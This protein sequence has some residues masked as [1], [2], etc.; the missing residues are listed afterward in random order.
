LAHSRFL[1]V[2]CQIIAFTGEKAKNFGSLPTAFAGVTFLRRDKFRI[3][4]F[5]LGGLS[6]FGLPIL[7]FGFGIF[8]PKAQEKTCAL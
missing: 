6:H 7:G 1:K 5:G 4:D 8:L 2:S 3:L